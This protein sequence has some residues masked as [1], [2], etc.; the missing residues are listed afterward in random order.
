MMPHTL[1]TA[2]F[3][4]TVLTA[5]THN[6]FAQEEDYSSNYNKTVMER[7]MVIG[8]ADRALDLTGSAQFIDKETLDQNNYTD[9]NLS[10]IHI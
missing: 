6:A 3:L 9:I 4:T 5:T 7:V 8:N 2:L 10:L 1:K